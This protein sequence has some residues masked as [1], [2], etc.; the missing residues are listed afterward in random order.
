[1]NA[2]RSPDPYLLPPRSG[3]RKNFEIWA[4]L[5]HERSEE[6]KRA[7]KARILSQC[8]AFA[9]GYYEFALARF[10]NP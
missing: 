2:G 7:F 9:A 6:Q 1:M 10:R 3:G 8:A 5:C 4:Y